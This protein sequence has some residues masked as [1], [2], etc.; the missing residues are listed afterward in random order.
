MD[1]EQTDHVDEAGEL[2]AGAPELAEDTPEESSAAA[3]PA[4]D[5]VELVRAFVLGHD[6]ALVPELVTGGTVAEVLSSVA[7][8]RAAYARIA[9][10]VRVEAPAGRATA[11]IAA[12]V[13]VV[14]AGGAAAFAVDPATLPAGELIRRGVTAARRP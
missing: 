12:P 10:Q 3:E 4:V 7:A 9:D 1:D 8:A 2:T 11:P 5:D 6:A 14:P 13:P